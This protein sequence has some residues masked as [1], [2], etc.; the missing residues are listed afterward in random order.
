MIVEPGSLSGHPREDPGLHVLVLEDELVAPL[1][2]I[3]M[4]ERLPEVL[5]LCQPECDT[6]KLGG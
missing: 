3:G 4:D 1:T 5:P 6:F 2:G